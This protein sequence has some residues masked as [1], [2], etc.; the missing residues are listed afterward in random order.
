MSKTSFSLTKYNS[1]S[2]A[3]LF[4]FEED[5]DINLKEA[6]ASWDNRIRINAYKP[7]NTL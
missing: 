4:I 2:D 6:V 7:Y 5:M 1:N 3:Y